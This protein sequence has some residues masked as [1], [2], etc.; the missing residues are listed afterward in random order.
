TQA[1]LEGV[2]SVQA[3]LEELQREMAAVNGGFDADPRTVPYQEAVARLEVLA[4]SAAGLVEDI[5]ALAPPEALATNHDAI[6]TAV[7]TAAAAA[8]EALAGLQS[9][10]DGSQ[11]RNAIAAFD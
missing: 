8:D 10:D 3:S 2:G 6:R 7:T 1:Y 9:T 11:R 4:D 5:D